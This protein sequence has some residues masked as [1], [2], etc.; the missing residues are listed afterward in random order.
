MCATTNPVRVNYR[1]AAAAVVRALR[2]TLE[3]MDNAEALPL[4]TDRTAY[5]DWDALL[6][7]YNAVAFSLEPYAERLEELLPE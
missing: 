3:T 1:K 5:H 6:G 7:V 2:A 4:P